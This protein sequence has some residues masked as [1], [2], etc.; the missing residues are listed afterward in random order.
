MGAVYEKTGILVEFGCDFHRKVS[1]V[2][3][4][5]QGPDKFDL[6]YEH[7]FEVNSTTIGSPTSLFKV[8]VITYK[9][10]CNCRT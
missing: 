7:L 6:I 10:I 8:L 9:E 2:S 5:S 3:C 4:Q 1:D